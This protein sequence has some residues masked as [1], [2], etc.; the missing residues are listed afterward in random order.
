[1]ILPKIKGA[2]VSLYPHSASLISDTHY[3][4]FRVIADIFRD[5]VEK[6]VKLKPHVS[7]IDYSLRLC[8]QSPKEA[9]PSIVVFCTGRIFGDLKSLLARPHLKAQYAIRDRRRLLNWRHPPDEDISG[10]D[11]PRF[12]LY[13]WRG[14]PPRTLLAKGGRTAKVHIC[15]DA[16]ASGIRWSDFTMCAS[17]VASENGSS[18][19]I[20][21]LIE[22]DSTAYGLTVAHAFPSLFQP[23]GAEGETRRPIYDSDFMDSV[24]G[25]L[26]LGDNDFSDDEIEYESSEEEHNFSELDS[27]PTQDHETSK[28]DRDFSLDEDEESSTNIMMISDHPDAPDLDCALTELS[29]EQ[30]KKPN[31]YVSPDDSQHPIL[32]REVAQRHPGEERQVLIIHSLSDPRPGTLLCGSSYIGGINRPGQC[33]VW[34]VA[35][36]GSSG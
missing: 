5:N 17:R 18:S 16:E 7:D 27:P 6:D 26:H 2:P 23:L 30:S 14:A 8:G 20:A 11:I 24:Q 36:S 35:F 31:F 13:F 25:E 33:E 22:I 28:S 12:R 10:A 19:T 32:V 21:C 4:R 29:N 34:N 15:Q 3:E 9:H 1:L